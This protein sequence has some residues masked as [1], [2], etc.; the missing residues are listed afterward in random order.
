MNRVP[1][2][3]SSSGN[4]VL[5]Q[6]CLRLLSSPG[7][8]TQLI[9]LY[10]D[11]G[12][13]LS[14]LSHQIAR[15]LDRQGV[16][17]LTLPEHPIITD[18]SLFDG[19]IEALGLPPAY[20]KFWA[21]LASEYR[22]ALKLRKIDTAIINDLQSYTVL[23]DHRTPQTIKAIAELYHGGLVRS[24]V[25]CSTLKT[26]ERIAPKLRVAEIKYIEVPIGRM[27]FDS[28]YVSFVGDTLYNLTGSRELAQPLAL[29]FF[30]NSEGLVGRSINYIRSYVAPIESLAT[31]SSSPA[32]VWFAGFS[33]P[34]P[35]ETFP[36]WVMR[37]AYRPKVLCMTNQVID[38]CRHLVQLSSAEEGSGGQALIDV[39]MLPVPLRIPTISETFRF[40]CGSEAGHASLA[41]CPKCLV[42]DVASGRFPAWR[43]EWSCHG[44]CI[45]YKHPTPSILSILQTPYADPFLKGWN[46][47]CE[48]TN[49]PL[50]RI[51]RKVVSGSQSSEKLEAQETKMCLLGW[52]VQRWV[53]EQVRTGNYSELTDD[54]VN[55]LLNILLH[56]PYKNG[57]TG[58][59]A[60]SYIESRDLFHVSYASNIKPGSFYNGRK[61]AS[62]LQTL[63]AYLMIGVAYG[64]ISSPEAVFL[65]T[66]FKPPREMFPISRSH[67]SLSAMRV[68]LPSRQLAIVR[69]ANRTLTH[70]TYQQ[71]SWVFDSAQ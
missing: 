30:R 25:L 16:N 9:F 29:D 38:I 24:L 71:I 18:A 14:A 57:C 5:L 58:G 32:K 26:F 17:V 53:L 3:I 8:K 12:C 63:I 51:N 52:R 59:F 6:E 28:T 60:R 22:A 15:R 4:E 44:H 62:P 19:V 54:G 1:R 41:Y 40:H 43:S 39:S 7:Q 42:D 64:V 23:G 21:G 34:V 70:E 47:F 31:H 20:G 48:Y 35:D 61:T 11:S 50:P 33:R 13:G 10:G 55:Y 46:A 69:R 27:S 56:E 67:I 66:V 68:F 49:S 65:R 37:N 2:W 45:C 36:S